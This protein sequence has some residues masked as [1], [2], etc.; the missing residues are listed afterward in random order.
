[1]AWI[2]STIMLVVAIF[3]MISGICLGIKVWVNRNCSLRFLR[4]AYF[5]F[6]GSLALAVGSCA[7]FL[8]V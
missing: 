8:C 4:E 7:L 2:L 6:G 5:L 3:M 1:M